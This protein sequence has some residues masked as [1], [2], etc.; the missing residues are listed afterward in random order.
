MKIR[1]RRVLRGPIWIGLLVTLI[2]ATATAQERR[3][4]LVIGNGDY[5]PGRLRNPV[6]NA[7][8]I[9]QALCR[10]GFEVVAKENV[11]RVAMYEAISAFGNR[12]K[13]TKGVGVFYFS[14][15]GLQVQGKNFMVPSRALI[16]TGQMVETAAIDVNRVLGEMDAAQARVNIVVLDASRDNPYGRFR[17]GSK[18]IDMPPGAVIAYA[19]SPGKLAEDGAGQQ[20]PYTAALVKHIATPGLNLEQ[21]FRRV[22]ADVLKETGGRQSAWVTS[23][24]EEDFFF[25]P[26][27]AAASPTPSGLCPE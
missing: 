17:S 22:L 18:G 9:A 14:G 25:F 1:S 11:D 15:R 16:T 19:T 26:A 4:A 27:S 6:N 2:A 5:D 20:S 8:A 3:I 21:L 10:A 7:R 24:L 13:E 23:T 12:L